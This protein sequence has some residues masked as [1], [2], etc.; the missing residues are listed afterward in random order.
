MTCSCAP[1]QWHAERGELEDAF[2]YL[3]ETQ[4]WDAVIDFVRS[5]GRARFEA[6]QPDVLV[7]WLG[8][9]PEEVRR[10]RTDAALSWIAA[11]G[12]TGRTLAADDEATRLQETRLLEPWAEAALE[13][14]RSSWVVFHAEPARAMASAERALECLE[15]IGPDDAGVDV[16]G[17]TSIG[18]I[19]VLGKLSMGQAWVLLGDEVQGRKRLTESAVEAEGTYLMWMLH[20]LGCIGVHR[21]PRR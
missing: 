5:A 17:L 16:L 20:A 4:D 8:Q 13:A 7:H 2:E 19:R 21:C 10:S 11:L 18:L 3:V 12:L 15:A 9:I 1:Q 6:V 14:M